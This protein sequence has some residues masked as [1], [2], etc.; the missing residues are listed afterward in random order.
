[1]GITFQIKDIIDIILVAILMYLCYMWTRETTAKNIF[2]GLIT[3]VLVWFAVTRV[4]KMELLGA[5]FDAIFN[6]GGI[7][8]V[9]IF[10]SEIRKF[11]SKIGS[12]NNYGNAI[13]GI[14]IKLHL[15]RESQTISLPI[16]PIVEAIRSMQKY[17]WGAL[18]VIEKNDHLID[19]I[20]TGERIDANINTRLIENI[21]FKNAPLHDGALIISNNKLASAGAILPI[22]HSNDIPKVFGLRH[23]A[24][25]G[26]SERSDAVVIV[27]SE[28]T[29]FISLI[30]KETILHNISLDTLEKE[31]TQ[32]M[33][34]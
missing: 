30:Y 22:S 13:K 20:E 24:A 21:F 12:S 8:L 11:F 27:L 31:I 4:F 23:R 34:L 14:L 29:A 25:I 5:I 2:T 19:Y 3:F 10:Q 15:R 33:M 9:V 1:M 16:T 18:I 7:S 32:K 6:V 26:I 28:E 17:N